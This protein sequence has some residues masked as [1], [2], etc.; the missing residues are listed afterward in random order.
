VTIPVVAN[1]DINTPQDVVRVLAYTG[2]DAV[3]IGRAAQ[4]KPWIFKEI[5]HFMATGEILPPPKT[6]EVRAC[7]SEHLR[8]HHAFYGEYTGVRTA[9]KHLQWYLGPVIGLNHEFMDQLMK[10][11]DAQEQLDVTD[12]FF[13][14][15]SRQHDRLPNLNQTT[16][17]PR[18]SSLQ[19]A[20]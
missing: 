14:R 12:A 2:A 1:G 15:L 9:R 13:E 7:M 17:R 20:A 5:L 3:M 8:D 6:E 16:D 10:I 11:E 18:T 19:L 4:G